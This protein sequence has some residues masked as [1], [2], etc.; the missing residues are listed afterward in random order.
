MTAPQQTA[1]I[2]RDTTA[3]VR[4]GVHCDYDAM[5]LMIESYT[6]ERER[7]E[8]LSSLAGFA[9]AITCQYARLVGLAPLCQALVRHPPRSNY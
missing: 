1:D 8:L 5:R 6:D 2:L 7:A 9:A 4:A 3:L